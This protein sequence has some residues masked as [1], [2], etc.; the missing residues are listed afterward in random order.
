MSKSTPKN[1]LRSWLVIAL[2]ASAFM[3]LYRATPNEG[4]VRELTQTEFYKALDEGK[5]VEPVTRLIEQDSGATAL[6][7]EM[8]L[9]RLK[10]DGSP[11]K[12]VYRV[13][14]V[15]GENEGLMEDLF[16]REVKVKVS[17]RQPRISPLMMQVLFFL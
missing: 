10:E 13:A 16:S 9:D 1:G 8:E 5:I 3:A 2:V 15:P 12:A 4:A 11:M 6:V 7:G 14:L 17:V